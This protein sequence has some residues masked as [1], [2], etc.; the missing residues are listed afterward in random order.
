MDGTHDI[1]VADRQ[2]DKISHFSPLKKLLQR[3]GSKVVNLA[4]GTDIPDA[5]SGFRAYSREAALS[6]NIVTNFSYCMETII[7]AGRKR[8]AITHVPVVTNPK[9]RESRL[10]KSMRQHVSKSAG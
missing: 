4:A 7:H 5:P 8:I 1:V 2:T 10:F 6:L 9:T 3:V